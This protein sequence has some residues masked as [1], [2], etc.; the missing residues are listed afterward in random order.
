MNYKKQI[1]ALLLFIPVFI[2]SQVG[3]ISGVVT[4]KQT[5]EPLIGASVTVLGINTG[6]ATNLNGEF[7]IL[8]IPVGAYSLK[9]TYIGYT[10]AKIENVRVSTNITTNINFKLNSEDVQL[11][12]ITIV[13]ER[14]LIEKNTTNS[15]SIISREDLANLPIRTVNDIVGMQAGAVSKD[16]NIYVRGSRAEGIAY[17]VDGVLVNN[18]VFGNAQIQMIN[19]AIEEVQFQAGGYSAEF[20]GANGGIVSTQSRAGRENYDF[21]FEVITDNFNKVGS[22]YLGGYS[23]GYSEYSLTAG[24][25]LIPTYN[26]LKFF[27][28]ANNNYSRSPAGFYKGFDF[29]NIYDPGLAAAGSADTFSLFR[30]TG[31][32]A[33]RGSNTYQVMG[34]LTYDLQPISIRLNGN[35]RTNESLNGSGN[36]NSAYIK[37]PNENRGRAGLHQDYTLTSSLKVTH[38]ISSSAFYDVILNYFNDFGVDMDPIFKHNIKAYGDSIENAKKG[39]TLRSDGSIPSDQSAYGNDFA[40]INNPYNNY[41]KQKTLSLGGKVN[42]LYQAGSHHELK[43]GGEYNYYTIRRYSIAPVKL[44]GTSRSVAD[45]DP[46]LI[47]TQLDNYGYDVY[48]NESDAGLTK[49][50]HP[51]FAAAYLQDKLEYSD[52]VVNLGFRLDYIDIDAKQ[53]KDPQNI[54]FTPD[55]LIADTSLVTVDPI[56][57]ISPRLGFSFPVTDRT[58]FHAQYGKF[59]QQSRLRDVY[60]GY[61]LASANI[62]GGLAIQNPVGFGLKPERT[63][64]YEIGFKQQI[65]ENLAF[66]ITGFYK[67]IKDQIQIRQTFGLPNTSTPTY[68]AWVNGDF[69]T[70]KGVE[71][72][73]DLRR[74][75]R[76]AAS[77][78]YTYSDAE[79]TGSNPST[80]FRMIWQSATTTPFFPQQIAAL[81]FNQ[82]HKGSINLDYRY[83]N[84]DGPELLGIKLL[85]NFGFNMLFSFGSGYNFTRWIGFENLR[86]PIEP[87][88]A[89]QTPWTYQVDLKVD[90]T[91]SFVGL[92]LNIY[93]WVTNLLNTENVRSVFNN[94]GDAYDDGYLSSDLGKSK[95][96]GYEQ[97]GT[98]IV[99]TYK[100]LYKALTYDSNKLGVPRQ[101]RLG[102]R[103]NY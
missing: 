81:D 21:S 83:A 26:K 99:N 63:T 75:Q 94:S 41:T 77:F 89:S 51:I 7:V 31:Y 2:F 78:D 40:S 93:V 22:E 100:D 66:D 33:Q 35:F 10:E 37:T 95:I 97:F 36:Y 42:L 13:A 86:T 90:K 17:Y 65:G 74:T 49:S 92:N 47:Y 88:N 73:L 67:D 69:S 43:M 48:G 53:F 68:Y 101:V 50:K 20:G 44:A 38:V 82:T 4:D 34:N 102:V 72:K 71:F 16:G 14:P 84:E 23:Y 12:T 46:N 3:K 79:G 85:E 32:L 45:G 91:V 5:G 70:V 96:S 61:N 56:A 87:L 57:Q 29:K 1:F 76:I 64:S 55:N 39:I 60:Q 19:N 54:A 103:L 98:E 28:A 15:T 58:V 27:V 80:G 25:P 59:I 8:N 52:L 30:P 6:A 24:G 18:P 11:Q 62:K 9:A